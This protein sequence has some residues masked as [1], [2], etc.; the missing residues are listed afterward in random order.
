MDHKI[1]IIVPAYNAASYISQC[2][3]SLLD[4]TYTNTQIICVD[5]G[6]T[7]ATL[8]ILNEYAKKDSRILVVHKENEGVSLA[9]NAALDVAT[10]DYLLFVDGDDWIEPETC[11]IALE[12]LQK[13]NADVVMWSYIREMTGESRK[14]NIYEADWF[15]DQQ[16][17][18]DKLYRRMF[19]AYGD[20]TAK[21]E[22]ADALCTVWGKLYRRDIVEE[23]SIRFHDIRQ[24]GTYE[25]GLFNLNV[26]SK[27][28][29]AVFLNRH[30]YHYRR[31]NSTSITTAYNS[32]MPQQWDALF[33]IL[34]NYIS[35]YAA[36]ETFQTALCNRIVFSLIA[37]G[38]NETE[39][40]DG[41]L[42]TV[43]RIRQLINTPR[44]REAIRECDFHYLPLHWKLFFL[45]AKQRFS[46]GVYLL[47]L[48]IQK[49]R[50][51]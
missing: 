24:I 11:A 45:C 12:A 51:R 26:F 46:V 23:N 34:Q 1:S 35:E 28:K 20:E 33:H 49:I 39:K 21:P 22:N 18:K 19:G 4:Q 16:A 37:L 42:K 40:H 50:G 2:I 29:A 44:Y 38:I 30:L 6:S 10:G 3:N 13:Y 41:I 5:D 32:N 17:V 15:F 9:R 43:N 8:Q 36:E 27:T 14:K 7:D 48:A 31:D 47:L 25:D